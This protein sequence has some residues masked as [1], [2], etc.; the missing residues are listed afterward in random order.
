MKLRNFNLCAAGLLLCGSR[1]LPKVLR[2]R[3]HSLQRSLQ[4]NR[5]P[6]LLPSSR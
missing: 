4:R 3:P 1:L 2:N 5:A 6:R